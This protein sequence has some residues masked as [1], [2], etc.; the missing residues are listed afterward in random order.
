[1]LTRPSRE[2][3]LTLRAQDAIRSILSEPGVAHS[4]RSRRSQENGEIRRVVRLRG[5]R[6]RESGLSEEG[7]EESWDGVRGSSF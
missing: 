5:R 3:S 1:M 4:A 2:A 7:F 6:L